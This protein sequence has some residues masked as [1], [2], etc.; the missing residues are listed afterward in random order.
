MQPNV[1]LL[2]TELDVKLIEF[3]LIAHFFNIESSKPLDLCLY[4]LERSFQKFEL[5]RLLLTHH[6]ISLCFEGYRY[7]TLD[8]K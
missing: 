2:S 8:N 4:V 5:H 1:I 3:H 7:M 6:N